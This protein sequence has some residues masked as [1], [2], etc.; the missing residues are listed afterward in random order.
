MCA[1]MAGTSAT[2]LAQGRGS[3]ATLA[4]VFVLF[5]DLVVRN[6]FALISFTYYV[7]STARMVASY[8]FSLCCL[9]L[10]LCLELIEVVLLTLRGLTLLIFNSSLK[11]MISFTGPNLPRPHWNF[12]L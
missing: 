12:R 2:S 5:I 11:V 1:F 7:P 10:L 3:N 8:P 4:S 9:Y 6:F